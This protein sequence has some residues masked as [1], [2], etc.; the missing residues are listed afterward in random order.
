MKAPLVVH[1]ADLTC[2]CNLLSIIEERINSN[3]F[4]LEAKGFSFFKDIL[5]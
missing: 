5:E 4:D 3:E 2:N 1:Q